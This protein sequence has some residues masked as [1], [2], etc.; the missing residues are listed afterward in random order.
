M[1]EKNYECYVGIDVAKA[2]FDV[3]IND[4]KTITR[5][6]NTEAGLQELCETLRTK[7]TTL[8]VMEAS[9]G[10]EQFCARW[11]C[12]QGYAV[13]IVNAKR[14]RDFAK[15]GGN[16]AKTDKIDARVIRDYGSV[17]KPLAQTALS[18]EHLR[19]SAQAKRRGQLVRMLTLEKQ[20]SEHASGAI[21]KMIEKSICTL[22]KAI[23]KI[24]AMQAELLKK[25]KRL[26]EKVE[27]LEGIKGV[28]MGTAMQVVIDLPEIGTLTGKEVA[29]IVG[30]AP[31]NH[32]SGTHRGKRH[33]S[34]G[35][36]A[37]RSMLYMAVLS[38]KKFNPAIKVFYER[39]IAKGK[40]KKVAIVACMRKLIVTM[41]A[42]IRDGKDWQKDLQS[43]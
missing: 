22:E 30:V 29:A 11:L 37:I 4:V 33:I 2:F 10:Y 16:L 15:A 13:A 27:R 8:I 9:G 7:D 42:M 35:R 43:M 25:E 36:G 24:D 6:A 40:L 14:V 32:D 20:H 23:K 38:A 21:K 1:T 18:D 39:L 5:Y 3:A 12:Q 26:Q 19:L 17:F 41:N 34:G 28:G 31:Y